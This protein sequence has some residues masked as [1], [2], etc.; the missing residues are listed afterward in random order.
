MPRAGNL[1]EES[2]KDQGGQSVRLEQRER[3]MSVRSEKREAIRRQG[4]ESGL[5]ELGSPGRALRRGSTRS[6]IPRTVTV[7]RI[8]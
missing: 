4:F 1:S 6:D 7:L 3:K 8:E 2:D 5:N